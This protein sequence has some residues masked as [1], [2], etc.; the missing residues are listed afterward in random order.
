MNIFVTGT[1]LPNIKV[2]A[3]CHKFSVWS[4][5]YVSWLFIYCMTKK[6]W[7]NLYIKWVKTSWTASITHGYFLCDTVLSIQSN[8]R[9][10][11][12]SPSNQI[13]TRNTIKIYPNHGHIYGLASFLVDYSMSK[14]SCPNF[15]VYSQY[16]N[17]KT[18][19]TYGSL[20][21][22]RCIYIEPWEPYCFRINIIFT[23]IYFRFSNF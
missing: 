22:V 15:M 17:G 6:S 12:L 11:P 10:I 2:R 14:K 21:L 4:S 3:K 5:Q 20:S 23:I 13:H 1:W 19:G 8:L 7:P 18:I 16:T 9:Q